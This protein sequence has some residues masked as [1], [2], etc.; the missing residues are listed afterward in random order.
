M[1][2]QGFLGGVVYILNSSEVFYIVYV[3]VQIILIYFYRIGK[4]EMK[5]F[6][7]IMYLLNLIQILMSDR[8]QLFLLQFE[9]FK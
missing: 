8:N 5:I 6:V 1:D 2:M 4:N 3:F 7:F 9:F